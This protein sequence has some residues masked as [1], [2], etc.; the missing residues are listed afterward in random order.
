MESIYDFQPI[1]APKID[2]RFATSVLNIDVNAVL[3]AIEFLGIKV[4]R[5]K[6]REAFVNREM[7][8]NLTVLD[9]CEVFEM[10][11]INTIVSKIPFDLLLNAP[12]PFICK[13][14]INK[15]TCYPLV[16]EVN[17]NSISLIYPQDNI[18]S[19]VK[20]EIRKESYEEFTSKWDSLIIL[21]L[22]TENVGDK[23]YQVNKLFEDKEKKRYFNSIKII[24]EFLSPEECDEIISFSENHNKISYKKS[25]IGFNDEEKISE[26]RTSY[27]F[28]PPI[29]EL[30]ILNKIIQ[31]SVIE[32]QQNKDMLEPISIARYNVDQSFWL[33]FDTS[34]FMP[35]T[36]T[37]VLY[38]N[39]NFDGGETYFSELDFKIVPKKGR[40]LF[41]PNL[42]RHSLPVYSA[43]AGLPIKNGSKYVL[44]ILFR[45]KEK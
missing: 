8:P 28:I 11:G 12:T 22:P 45:M 10:W 18:S 5:N 30:T 13:L 33:H 19:P 37:G 35:R 42:E 32:T 31:L 24:D 44:I 21:L 17:E 27:T 38:L 23:N 7:Y 9:F 2:I 25:A 1:H 40:M 6:I 14:E 43:H 4:T 3:N 26:Y 34:T 16:I 15:Q 20:R 36:Y 29:E 41:F 39:D